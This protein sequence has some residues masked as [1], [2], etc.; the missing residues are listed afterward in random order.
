MT[1]SVV[2][3]TSVTCVA[4]A[5]TT[6]TL[7]TTSGNAILIYILQNTGT[8]PTPTDNAG[9]SYSG[10]QVTGSPI[11][12]TND[13]QQWNLFLL[14]NITGKSGHTWSVSGTQGAI[15][16]MGV[17]EI[18][19][20]PASSILDV[21][22]GTAY[23]NGGGF[24]NQ[25]TTSS[26]NALVISAVFDGSSTTATMTVGGGTGLTK[27]LS[28]ATGTYASAALGWLVQSSP[29]T[30][31]PSTPTWT[32][33]AGSAGALITVAIKPASAV[34]PTI[35]STSAATLSNGTTGY[36]ITG[37]GFGASQGAGSVTIGTSSSVQ[38]T[39]AVTQ[40]VTAWSD[41]SITF[42][43]VRG[44]LNY[45]TNVYLYVVT[46][47]SLT[48]ATGYTEQFY[49][50]AVITQTLVNLAGA[51]QASV[52]SITGL[53]YKSL[54]SSAT[55]PDKVATNLSTDGSGVL[56]WDITGLSLTS[57]S[58][59]WLFLGKDGA[60]PLGT[61]IRLTPTYS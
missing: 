23:I 2:Q 7:N 60:T 17:V 30:S 9:N 33:S 53:I 48:N 34:A 24:T 22:P 25:I 3:S 42:T 57:G 26:N 28:V 47:A 37:T 54:P 49:P 12:D 5:G 6:P 40:T 41:T 4:N 59:V 16:W 45:A 21:N 31:P 19:G 13:G 50:S 10:K 46:N 61:G 29:G 36:T 35:S 38:A 14:E 11:V 52:T 8:S 20:C 43:A 15:A 39:G 32:A 55:A 51:N 1:A 58:T 44:A 18:T 56:S 27:F